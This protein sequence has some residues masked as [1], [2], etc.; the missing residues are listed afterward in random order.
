MA[1]NMA[2]HDA[3]ERYLN[4]RKV[5]V[6]K[7]TLYN[8]SSQLKQFIEWCD[9][10]DD[11]PEKVA[12]IDGWDVS[13][14]KIYRRDEDGLEN[15]TLYNQMSAL[16]V[17][18]R[19]CESRELLENVSENMMMPEIED[20]TRDEKID[21]ERGQEILTNLRTYEY[22]SLKQVMF[23]LLWST[24]MRIRTARA[25][26]VGDYGSDGMYLRIKHR[27]ERGTPLKNGTAAERELNLHEWVCVVLDDYLDGRQHN[28]TDDHD[29]QPLLTT[30]Q[31]RAH[32][33]TLRKKVTTMTRP[34]EYESE[35]PLDREMANCEA[36]AYN[37][38][39]KFPGSVSPHPLR[40]SAIT[41]F[42][43][44][45]HSK[46]LIS[47]RMDVSVDVLEKHYD[48]RSESEKRELRR[49]MFEMD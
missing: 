39:C 40:R 11:R 26:D 4:E 1:R 3:V 20:G 28:V 12:A 18:F 14:F 35:C 41:N 22:A 13:D 27:P 29:R 16:R 8:H 47:D 31:G 33:T 38:A 5:D 44:D 34:C 2:V 19:W 9:A 17:F 23:S 48:A 6:S 21:A 30:E 49:E 24:G 43:N 46:E 45:G 32:R 10:G 7:S 25:L 42:L 37:A 15:T 36:T